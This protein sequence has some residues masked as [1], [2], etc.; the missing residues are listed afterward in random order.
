MEMGA[1]ERCVFNQTEYSNV[2]LHVLTCTNVHLHVLTCTN[3]H[4]HV[5]TCTNV[6]LYVL[7]CTNDVMFSLDKLLYIV[8]ICQY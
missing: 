2:H 7:T 5:L 6:H 1:S 3:V 4:L 8:A